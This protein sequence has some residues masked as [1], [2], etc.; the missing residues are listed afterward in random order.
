[1]YSDKDSVGSASMD[2]ARQMYAN[3][4]SPVL[5]VAELADFY[6]AYLEIWED[7]EASLLLAGEYFGDSTVQ[8]YYQDVTVLLWGRISQT[9]V[10]HFY[11]AESGDMSATY[12]VTAEGDR[13]Y[14]IECEQIGTEYYGSWK[15]LMTYALVLVSDSGILVD[16]LEIGYIDKDD[17]YV[18]VGCVEPLKSRRM[19]GHFSMPYSGLL[20]F[21]V[22]GG[23]SDAFSV[24]FQ[25]KGLM[26]IQNN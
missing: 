10:G 5:Y 14:R 20:D 8:L 24:R 23:V 26:E 12:S 4:V 17:N 25:P 13:K 2:L 9:G 19:K 3:T 16:R 11:L 1:M 22:S 7:R 21:K 6:E 15:K 18:Q